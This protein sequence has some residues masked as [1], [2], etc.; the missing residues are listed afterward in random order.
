M[1]FCDSRGV[2]TTCT[3]RSRVQ[4]LDAALDDAL[5][6][7]G[8]AI[9]AVDELL[10]EDPEFILGH[11]FRAG[12]LTQ[13]MESRVYL[14][15][16]ASIKAALALW[17]HANERERGH[18]LALRRWLAGDFYGAVRQWERVLVA[19]PHDLLAMALAHLSHVLL[20]NAI[21]QRDVVARAFPLWDPSMPGY[22]FVLGFYSFGLEETGD[23][24]RAEDY[25][26][27]A[28]AMRAAHPY[29]VHAVAHVMESQGRQND[30]VRLISDF[31]DTWVHS[32]FANHLWWHLALFHLDLGERDTV[33]SIYDQ[34]LRQA[35]GEES[36]QELDS[37]ALLWRL[38]LLDID[39]GQRW[40]EL[41]MKWAPSAEDS[42]YAFN[43]VHAMMAFTSAGHK[44]AARRLTAANER[45]AASSGDAST[46]SNV[47]MVRRIGLPF[48]RAIK[49][50]HYGD[51]ATA[52]DAL[53]PVRDNAHWLGGSSAQRDVIHWTLLETAIR[54]G[55][56][57]WARALAHERQALKPT[58]PQNQ[59]FVARA[60]AFAS[61]LGASAS[62]FAM[63]IN[64]EIARH[65]S[66][67]N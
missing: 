2:P 50:F 9:A 66:K 42:L 15:M 56:G 26:R 35:G 29:A 27:R 37:A 7:R 40:S 43:D 41:A 14:D 47:Q 13:A 34:G 52:F 46:Q 59:K 63:E 31:K 58:S 53:L 8:D 6:S 16:R 65:G 23:F 44:D 17:D 57:N 5:A 24:A 11:C 60:H 18:I 38:K 10:R 4:K 45:L 61:P 20:G 62:N 67:L 49:A 39:S 21:G 51:Y 3:D 1:G 19:Y 12:L 28:M 30:G 55:R 33:L 54:A 32:S 48:V 36:Y 25:G 22:D 64:N